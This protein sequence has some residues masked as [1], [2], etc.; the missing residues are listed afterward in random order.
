MCIGDAYSGQPISHPVLQSLASELLENGPMEPDLFDKFLDDTLSDHWFEQKLISAGFDHPFSLIRFLQGNLRAFVISANS[1][2]FRSRAA[3]ESLCQK[4]AMKYK[5]FCKGEVL[6]CKYTIYRRYQ[7]I[8]NEADALK[9]RF[10][11][12]H[13]DHPTM[14]QQY[15]DLCHQLRQI[16]QDARDAV[17]GRNFVIQ[18]LSEKDKEK[19]NYKKCPSCRTPWWDD[20][21]CQQRRCGHQDAPDWHKEYVAVPARGACQKHSGCGKRFEWHFAEPLSDKEFS[22]FW[23]VSHKPKPPPPQIHPDMK[24][25]ALQD[26]VARS[27]SR[28][29]N[30]TNIAGS[31][32]AKLEPTSDLSIAH[33]VGNDEGLY[34]KIT[35]MPAGQEGIRRVFVETEGGPTSPKHF[36]QRTQFLRQDGSLVD[37]SDLHVNEKLQGPLGEVI[38]SSVTCLPE[39]QRATVNVEFAHGNFIVT[40]DYRFCLGNGSYRCA[41]DLQQKDLVITTEGARFVAA[42]RSSTESICVVEVCFRAES[43][44]FV[45]VPLASAGVRF[46]DFGLICP[47]DEDQYMQFKIKGSSCR[48]GAGALSFSAAT[49]LQRYQ[50]HFVDFDMRFLPTV[51]YAVWVLRERANDFFQAVKALSQNQVVAVAEAAKVDV[52]RLVHRDLLIEQASGR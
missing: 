11:Q 31:L 4:L 48:A 33:N 32:T 39:S 34:M 17:F 41:R 37:V 8:V 51:P 47:Q 16:Q 28:T 5:D 46:A 49:C 14:Y 12:K 2:H 6:N 1:L 10:V 44:V 40:D 20:S 42:T 26:A 38:V 18:Q 30:N 19:R 50:N 45:S 25:K 24:K 9:H 27:R 52:A 22:A 15:M 13:T 35:Y 43:P 3:N 36:L 21:G 29:M 7:N 23:D